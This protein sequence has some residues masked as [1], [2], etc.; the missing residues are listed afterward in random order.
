MFE[1]VNE[2]LRLTP[3]LEDKLQVCDWLLKQET[4]SHTRISQL[5]LKSRRSSKIAS[6]K[7]E[8]QVEIKDSEMEAQVPHLYKRENTDTRK[9]Y[10]LSTDVMELNQAMMKIVKLQAAPDVDI[11]TFSGDP[12]EYLYYV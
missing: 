12:L 6:S 1:I 8:V 9:K 5:G 3:L 4:K 10:A 7:V 2:H 11:D